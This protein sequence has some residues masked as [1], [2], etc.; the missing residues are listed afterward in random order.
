[1]RWLIVLVLCGW[2]GIALAN[3]PVVA[4]F[5]SKN[6]AGLKKGFV[7]NLQQL[8]ETKLCGTVLLGERSC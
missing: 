6:D 3:K 8:V 2:S 5:E 1:M 7:Q 4:V